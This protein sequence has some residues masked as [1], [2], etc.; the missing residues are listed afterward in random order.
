MNIGKGEAAKSARPHIGFLFNHDQIHQI[1][2]SL[3]VAAMLADASP[4]LHV[5]VASTN[6]HIDTEV[7]RLLG[8][9]IP[10][11][12]E[13]RRLGLQ[14][15]TSRSLNAV[16]GKLLPAAKL[17]LYRDNLEYFRSLDAL[18]V[19]ERTS[20]ILKKRYGL[21]HLKMILI[22]HGAGDR[23]IGF[24]ASTATFDYILAAG[25]KIRD[26]LIAEADVTPSKIRIVG[27]PKFDEK[28]DLIFDVELIDVK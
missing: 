7:T 13:R 16:F 24:G 3:P 2:H 10:Q 25:Q 23:A 22:D 12:L 27:Y 6:S 8:Q 5:S 15:L 28:A 20:L 21:N 26:R 17:L 14:S 9:D 19:T 4:D 11:N 18:I 1:A